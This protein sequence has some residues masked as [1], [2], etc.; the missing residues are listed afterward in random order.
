MSV[1]RQES[2]FRCIILVEK[3]QKH[4]SLFLVDL[5]MHDKMAEIPGL[6]SFLFRFQVQCDEHVPL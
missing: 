1:S 4:Q 6:V 5:E 3:F 2:K